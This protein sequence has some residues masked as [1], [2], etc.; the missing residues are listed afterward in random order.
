MARIVIPG[1]RKIEVV[2]TEGEGGTT[3]YEDLTNKP[4]INNV[5]IV[6]NM[7]TTDL[8]LTDKS[9]T[10]ELVPADSK[11]VGDK[12]NSV[13]NVLTSNTESIQNLETSQEALFEDIGEVD[14]LL[15]DS[16]VVVEAI[17]LLK[18]QLEL[19]KGALTQA[20]NS[21]IDLTSRVEAL[22][23]KQGE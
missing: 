19:L 10:E 2:K 7:N 11:T 18:A 12:F 3:N 17:N 14:T 21:I 22:E 15:T 1:F 5:P 6:G 9:L 23:N 13:Q 16:K 4:S 20:N 8:H